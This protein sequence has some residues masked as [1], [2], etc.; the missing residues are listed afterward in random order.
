MYHDTDW[1]FS[2]PATEFTSLLETLKNMR[3]LAH[4]VLLYVADEKRQFAAFSRWL[5]F[6]IDFEATEPDSQSRAEIEGRDSGVD[7]SL[8]LEYVRYGLQQSSLQ[9]YLLPEAML[10]AEDKGKEKETYEDTRKAIEVFKEAQNW[11]PEAVCLEHV[12][13]HLKKG[14]TGLLRQVSKWQESGIQMDS[15][16]ILESSQEEGDDIVADMRMV[17]EVSPTLRSFASQQHN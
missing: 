15:A 9:P 7:I 17:Y 13:S 6:V 1:I 2:S 10:E 12:L 14:T 4:T 3:L 5:R 8:V 16:I 11:R